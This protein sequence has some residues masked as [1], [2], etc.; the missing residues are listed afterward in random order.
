MIG[1]VGNDLLIGGA[2]NDILSG[3]KGKDTFDFNLADKGTANSPSAD[4]ITDFSIKE[5]DVLDLRDLLDVPPR[6]KIRHY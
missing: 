5:K 3:G 4:T 6:I 2:G 1:E